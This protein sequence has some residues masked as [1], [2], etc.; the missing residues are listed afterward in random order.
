M[1]TITFVRHGQSIANA[2]GITMAHDAIPLSELGRLHAQALACLLP[3]RPSQI[4]ASEYL[5]AQHTAQPYC[6]RFGML[7]QIHPLLH[8][9]S[10][11]D[12]TLLEGMN[13]EQRRPIAEAYWQESN[14]HKRMGDNAETFVEF[15]RRVGDFLPQLHRLPHGAVL[16]G[17]GMW[18]GM[19]IWKLLG[20]SATDSVGM[21][22][23]RSFQLGLTMPNGA[24]Y[25]LQENASGHW[26]AQVDESI[27]RKMMGMTLN[28]VSFDILA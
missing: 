18:I 4:L 10:I 5:R 20:F 23:F 28:Q 8:E 13:G 2:G 22:S 25:H 14:P 21:K 16:F 7:A 26:H 19:L 12:P 24:V 15:E 6:N 3:D 9:F 1:K 27:M 17:H 11:I